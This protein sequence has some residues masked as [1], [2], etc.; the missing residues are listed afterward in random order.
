MRI[1]GI[2]IGYIILL[3]IAIIF[4][5]RHYFDDSK[6]VALIVKISL[7]QLTI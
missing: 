3:I 4:G 5:V 7:T 1:F 6:E 2:K